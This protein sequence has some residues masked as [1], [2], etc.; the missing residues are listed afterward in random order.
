MHFGQWPTALRWTSNIS[1]APS[2]KAMLMEWLYLSAKWSLTL[3]SVRHAR[4]QQQYLACRWQT[5]LRNFPCTLHRLG[6]ISAW[7]Y[8]TK[9]MHICIKTKTSSVES[10]GTSRSQDCSQGGESTLDLCFASPEE[11]PE[12]QRSRRATGNRRNL[13]CGDDSILW[14][15]VTRDSGVALPG[16]DGG[17]NLEGRP[18]WLSVSL[19]W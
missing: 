6:M 11:I 2:H 10:Q 15:N 12:W 9:N 5:R 1:M 16:C 13:H 18:C 19:C 14:A 8:K 7:W 4:C 17:L 3:H